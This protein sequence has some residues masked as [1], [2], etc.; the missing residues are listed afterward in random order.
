MLPS[1]R[2]PRG[3]IR[4][5]S[6]V[7]VRQVEIKVQMPAR[8]GV[9]V[10]QDVLEGAASGEEDAL[11]NAVYHSMPPRSDTSWQLRHPSTVR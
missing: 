11:E 10:V 4:Q 9:D 6:S 2:S 5:P 1:I 3:G 8:A 7:D